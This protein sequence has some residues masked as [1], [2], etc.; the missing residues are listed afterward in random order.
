MLAFDVVDLEVMRRM[1]AKDNALKGLAAAAAVR[2][3]PYV[4]RVIHDGELRDNAKVAY[5]HALKAFDRIQ[6]SKS[7][8]ST[9]LDDAKLHAELRDAQTNLRAAVTALRDGPQKK[10]KHRF[11]NLVFL[12]VLS[13]GIALVVS[14]G[15]RNKALDLL[16]GAEEEFDYTSTT[17]A[18]AATPVTPVAPAATVNGD[19]PDAPAE[20]ETPADA[21]A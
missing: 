2:E 8:A 5:A 4:S 3:N 17:A 15:L 10:K 14:E 1:S 16:F 9:L 18:P 7:P 6:S 20:A 12:T 19:A 11:R 13:A 21:D